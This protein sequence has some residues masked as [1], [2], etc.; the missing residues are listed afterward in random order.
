MRKPCKNCGHNKFSHQYSNNKMINGKWKYIVN[1]C[2]FPNCKC[3]KY[4]E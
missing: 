4:K 3:K 2:L 1:K